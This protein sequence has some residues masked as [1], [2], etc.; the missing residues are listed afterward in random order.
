[1]T[2]KA[3]RSIG[4]VAWFNPALGYGFAT[5]EDESKGQI[6]V[7]FTELKQE[8]YRKLRKDQKNFFY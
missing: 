2:T 4:T 3:V 5:T 8:G 1:M 6:F 7:H